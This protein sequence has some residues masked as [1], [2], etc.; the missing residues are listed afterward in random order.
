MSERFDKTSEYL[1]ELVLLMNES[2]G[3]AGFQEI[4]PFGDRHGSL[5][6]T[7]HLFA[8]GAR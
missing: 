8:G 1:D 7:C 4:N 5:E 3:I 2:V 6:R